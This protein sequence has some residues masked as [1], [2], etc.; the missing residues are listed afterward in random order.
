MELFGHP[1]YQC[2]DIYL[3]ARPMNGD[4][5]SIWIWVYSDLLVTS[6]WT[7]SIWM[8]MCHWFEHIQIC[9]MFHPFEQNATFQMDALAP[10]IWTIQIYITEPSIWMTQEHIFGWCKYISINRPN[11]RSSAVQWENSNIRSLNVQM[12]SGP[13]ECLCYSNLN[14]QNGQGSNGPPMLRQFWRPKWLT[15]LYQ[16]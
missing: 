2:M 7:S 15:L 8:T 5:L 1:N 11:E 9:H 14:C 6:I 4:S 3:D 13:M 12:D 16:I 10:C